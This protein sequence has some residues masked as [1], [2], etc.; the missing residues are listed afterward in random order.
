MA[1]GSTTSENPVRPI[2]AGGVM[3]EVGLTVGSLGSHSFEPPCGAGTCGHGLAQAT[4]KL[5]QLIV[6]GRA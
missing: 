3:G 1:V 6:V 2:T 4:P 5:T